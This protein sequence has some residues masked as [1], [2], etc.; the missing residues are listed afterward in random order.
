M[1]PPSWLARFPVALFGIPVGLFALA[2][3]WRRAQAFG[4]SWAQPVA[5][6]LAWTA[7]GVLAVLLLLYL[8][9]ALWHP[10]AI[11]NEFTHPL[12][13][14]L[15]ALLPVSLLLC[16]VSFGST[17]HN[18]WLLLALLALTLQAVLAIRIGS[19]ISRA[20]LPAPA[21]TPA[22]YV[23]TV[24]GGF[25]GALAL[26]TLGYPGWAALLFGMGLAAW[27]L[28]EARVLNRLFEGT[29]PEALRPTIGLEL[30]PATV[31]ALTVASIWPQF[32]GDV[33]MIGLGFVAGPFVA[34]MV[35]Y[36][37][38]S[39]VPFSIGFWSFSFPAAALAAVVL[40]AVRRGGWPPVVGGI[41]LGLAS[42]VIAFLAWR[43]LMLL[44][45]GRLIPVPPP[46][47]TPP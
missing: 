15:M 12:A 10:R 38:W 1:K 6:A 45:Q 14:S 21:I 34:V 11:A 19:L 7:L 39:N 3:A 5:D 9:K 25:V 23:P 24:A 26:N 43:T 35:R 2:G 33:L 36:K 41:A 17:H 22:L 42:A 4:W 29:M 32:P 28:L 18:G 37:W 31:G 47:A 46:Q 30:A 20:A 40:E 16:V 27:A 44:L 8:A 13:G